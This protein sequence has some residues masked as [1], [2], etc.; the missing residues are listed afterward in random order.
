MPVIFFGHGNPMN[1]LSE[2]AYTEGWV[3]IGKSIPCP[4]AVIAV[5]I[6]GK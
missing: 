5:Q 2:N 3:S 4:K 6:G 1:A